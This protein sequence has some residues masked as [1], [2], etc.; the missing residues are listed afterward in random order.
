MFES[1][2]AHFAMDAGIRGLVV[3]AAAVLVGA[4]AAA[5]EQPRHY[6]MSVGPGR[7]GVL[8]ATNTGYRVLL[9]PPWRDITPPNLPGWIDDV[10]FV[11]RNAGWLAAGDCAA[12][13]GVIAK[14]PDGGRSWRRLTTRFHHT[15][16]AGA[17][18]DLDFVDRRNGWLTWR[19]PTGRFSELYRTRDGGATW[20]Q[21][22]HRHA[23]GGAERVTFATPRRGWGVG[24]P[25]GYQGGQLLRTTDGGR[26][27]A[28]EV[29]VAAGFQALPAFRGRHGVA[30]V[31]TR[32][33]LLV[34][35][36]HD[37]GATWSQAARL[38]TSGTVRYVAL[39]SPAVGVWWIGIEHPKRQVLWV[40]RDGGR[41]WT[42]AVH[43]RA[44]SF[45]PTSGR[46]AWGSRERR[47]VRTDDAGRTWRH[48][49]IR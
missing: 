3:L 20:R 4:A 36:T 25:P 37:A 7:V 5:A 15:C 1:C 6:V 41:R 16:N 13:T 30:A 27:W 18:L 8:E 28:P 44:V 14:T 17:T 40:T 22:R 9:G 39:E 49:A 11:D 19:E 31:A 24:E 34:Y 23:D 35:E 10:E 29:T 45:V 43:P 42:R 38:P 12:G 46:K 48:A 47:L 32:G 33:H 21:V 26:T 2:R